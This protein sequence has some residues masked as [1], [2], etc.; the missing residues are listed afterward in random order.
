MT[1]GRSSSQCFR[2]SSLTQAFPPPGFPTLHPQIRT[3]PGHEFLLQS[4][5]ETELRAWHRALRAVIERLVR[6]V[7]TPEGAR[8]ARPGKGGTPVGQES[9]EAQRESLWISDEA[10]LV[11][12]CP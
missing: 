1:R 8:E 9:E 7:Q 6:R 2:L 12:P 11:E 4:D 5:E 10:V 3:V